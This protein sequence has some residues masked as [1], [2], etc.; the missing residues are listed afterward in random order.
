MANGISITEALK[1]KTIRRAMS[2]GNVLALETGT[3]RIRITWEDGEPKIQGID[4]RI[5]LPE[6]VLTG[7]QGYAS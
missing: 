3:Q 4:V 2:D 6:V 5:I 1:G 7:A